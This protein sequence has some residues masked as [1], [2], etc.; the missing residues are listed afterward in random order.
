M[1]EEDGKKA[2]TLIHESAGS[3]EAA[4]EGWCVPEATEASANDDPRA[5]ELTEHALK[6]VKA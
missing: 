5:S 3:A 4:A 6:Q 1:A 2:E